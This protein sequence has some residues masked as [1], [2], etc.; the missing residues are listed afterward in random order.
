MRE[1]RDY[2][3]TVRATINA[4]N[5]RGRYVGFKPYTFLFRGEKIFHTFSPMPSDEIN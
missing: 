1:T 4:K 3:W 2:G 5:S